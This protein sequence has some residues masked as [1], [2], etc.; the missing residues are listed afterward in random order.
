M[1]GELLRFS[2]LAVVA[3]ADRESPVLVV[4]SSLAGTRLTALP[5]SAEVAACIESR[6]IR[7]DE[8]AVF[9]ATGIDSDVIR[10]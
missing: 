5:I 8:N 1:I 2:R 10:K 3:F 6:S 4:E 9:R 7:L